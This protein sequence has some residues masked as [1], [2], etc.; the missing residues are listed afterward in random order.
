[1][2]PQQIDPPAQTRYRKLLDPLFSRPK[3]AE[4]VPAIR[5]HASG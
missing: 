5:A 3:M 1:M 4:L 2:I